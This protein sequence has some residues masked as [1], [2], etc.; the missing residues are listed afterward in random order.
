MKQVAIGWA[1]VFVGGSGI[2]Y[3][4]KAVFYYVRWKIRV[5]KKN[6]YLNRA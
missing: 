1:A 5:D 2:I 4:N 3:N 6:A